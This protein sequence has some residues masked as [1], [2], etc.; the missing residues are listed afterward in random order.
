[1]VTLTENRLLLWKLI[2]PLNSN[3]LAP[4]FC[5]LQDHASFK[6]NF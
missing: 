1:V 3:K 4:P 6:T 5:R 2:I